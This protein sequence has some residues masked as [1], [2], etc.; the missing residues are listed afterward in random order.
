[1]KSKIVDLF[2]KRGAELFT[3]AMFILTII[4]LL[5]GAGKIV[6]QALFSAAFGFLALVI[7]GEKIGRVMERI[8]FGKYWR[9]IVIIC[10]IIIGMW[11]WLA[12]IF[13]IILLALSCLL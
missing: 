4:A 1:M 12:L 7:G 13:L 10:F 8:G 6:L 2:K 9:T 3:L 5:C 11:N